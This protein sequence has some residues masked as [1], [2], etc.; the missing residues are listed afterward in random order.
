M[1][2]RH[3][4]SISQQSPSVNNLDAD[5]S[6]FLEAIKNNDTEKAQSLI[7]SLSIWQIKEDNGSTPLHYSVINN[8]YEL[9]TLIIEE[10]KKGLGISSKKLSN[11]INEKTNDG[12]TALHYAVYND[13]IEMVQLLKK[14][15]AKF[16]AATNLGKNVIHIAAEANHPTMLLYLLINE[17][18]DIFCLDDNGST[19]LHWACYSGGYEAVNFLLSLN[20]DV[21]AKDKED[22]TPLLLAV[23]NNKENIVRLLLMHK[24]DKNLPNKKKELPLDIAI[25]KN[26]TKII[27][28]LRHKEYNPLCT[29]EFPTKYIQPSD[30]YKKLILIVIIIIELI[31]FILILPFLED[32][33]HMFANFTSFI[34]CLLSYIIFLNVKPGYLKDTK[35][36]KDCGGEDN[37]KPLKALL[38]KGVKLENYCPKCYVEKKN[39]IIHC[40]ICDKCV[41][42]ME[43]HCFWFNRC[44]SKRNKIFYIIFLIFTFIYAF[45]SM[46]I[47]SNL[48]FDTVTI[49]YIKSFF[50]SWFYFDIDRGFR[51]LGAGIILV[52]SF[53][54]SFPLFFLFMIEIVKECKLFGKKSDNNREIIS[55]NDLDN[56]KINNN[57][58]LIDDK[59]KENE[60]YNKKIEEIIEE[61]KIIEENNSN[62]EKSDEN[63]KEK[64]NDKENDINNKE[65]ENEINVKIPKENF[66]LIN[67]RPSEVK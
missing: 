12:L 54:V 27:E 13:N 33:S 51:V 56:N 24:A 18:L 64:E 46:F 41:L 25:K 35:L 3:H 66:P 31:I 7:S 10:V 22:I 42:E 26:N 43:H 2:S 17:P 65:Q 49:P 20:A 19:P 32:I 53:I 58:K 38:E 23:S 62:E 16:E 36:I 9:T 39:E 6:Q 57:L 34:L 63:E 8:N 60:I 47:C 11:F 40:F 61:E 1:F 28:L 59:D 55:E 30:V 50:P 14:H 29:L 4:S 15:G 37:N 67:A 5:S 48:I 21:N 45:E 52:F 44:I